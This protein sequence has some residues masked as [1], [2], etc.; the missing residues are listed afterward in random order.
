[1][2]D[3]VT[4]FNAGEFQSSIHGRVGVQMAM[5]VLADP[6]VM[7]G[8]IISLT[9]ALSKVTVPA[10]DIVNAYVIRKNKDAIRVRPVVPRCGTPWEN[11][12]KIKNGV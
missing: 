1:M 7:D 4:G 6:N 9:R 2:N 12:V 3:T 10:N 5:R 11:I 8:P